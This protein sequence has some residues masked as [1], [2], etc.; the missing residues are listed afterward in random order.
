MEVSNVRKKRQK[1]KNIIQ[2]WPNSNKSITLFCK[3]LKINPSF[4]HYWRAKLEPNYRTKPP[5]KKV[6]FAEVQLLESKSRVEQQEL[7]SSNKDETIILHYP[8]GCFLKFKGEIKPKLFH[9]INIAMGVI[10]ADDA[11]R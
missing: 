4:F 2:Q 7:I 6:S 8:N 5:T 11:G 1:W 9:T 10:H 3:E